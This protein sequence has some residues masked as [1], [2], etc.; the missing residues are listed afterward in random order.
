M[1]KK[2]YLDFCY[3]GKL[4]S[5]LSAQYIMGDLSVKENV[6]SLVYV[7]MPASLDTTIKKKVPASTRKRRVRKNSV[8][9]EEEETG[10]TKEA[11]FVESCMADCL[12]SI[13]EG[14]ILWVD[15]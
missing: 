8:G 11:S 2:I 9:T 6:R 7:N 3:P 12:T 13:I 14:S 1:S 15:N 4:D 10:E 5:S